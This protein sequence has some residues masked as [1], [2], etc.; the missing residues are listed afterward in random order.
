MHDRPRIRGKCLITWLLSL[1]FMMSLVLVPASA[2]GFDGATFAAPILQDVERIEKDNLAEPET[3]LRT[4]SREPTRFLTSDVKEQLS[5]LQLSNEIPQQAQLIRDNFLNREVTRLT[6]DTYEADIDQT[7]Q[8]VSMTNYA[9][10]HD[11]DDTILDG[12]NTDPSAYPVTKGEALALADQIAKDYQLDGYQLV[13]CSND[14][15]ATWLLLW[16][17]QLDNGVLNPYDMV[18]VTV[19]ARDGSVMLMDRNKETLDEA[20]VVVTETGVIRRSQPLR[21]ELGGLAVSSTELTVFRPNFYWESTEVAY[22]EADFIRLAWRV[23]LEDGSAIYIDARTGETLGGDQTLSM[24]SRAVCAIPN[25]AG[26]QDCVNYASKGL[27]ALGYTK[28]LND[29]CYFIEEADIDYI[30]NKSNLKALYLRCHGDSHS[31]RIMDFDDSRYERWNLSYKDINGGF[32][33]V[34]LDACYSAKKAYFSDAFLGE[35]KDDKC[36]VGWNEAITTGASR[37]F[38]FIFW[39][40]MASNTPTVLDAVLQARSS[41]LRIYSDCNPGF[42]GDVGFDGYAA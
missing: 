41:A 40:L 29:V 38:D 37:Y 18:T 24:R 21:Q 25:V 3:L 10:M 30:L 14:I 27:A 36:F 34:L 5:T 13:E 26:G 31:K 19:D 33:F 12:E 17:K 1:A 4:F 20:D 8:V 11:N 22:Q 15:P 16:H 6:F 35:K 32:R 7:G 9:D 2:A 23:T 39:N 28:H 42:R